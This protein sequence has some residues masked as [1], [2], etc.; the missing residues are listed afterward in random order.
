MLAVVL[1]LAVLTV[2]VVPTVLVVLT[3]LGMPTA[4]V[5]LSVLV[6]L[7]ALLVL[8]VVVVLTGPSAG[9][10]AAATVASSVHATLRCLPLGTSTHLR[11]GLGGP[12]IFPDAAAALAA[13]ALA[14]CTF[15]ATQSLR[16]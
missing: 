9:F 14:I 15:S 13:A 1:T 11:A 4:L 10:S 2:L 12:G 16:P 3:V 6:V 7:L 8:A 5:V